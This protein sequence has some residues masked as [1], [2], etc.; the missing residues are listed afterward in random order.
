[1]NFDL[2]L[3]IRAFTIT[4]AVISMLFLY[5]SYRLYLFAPLMPYILYCITFPGPDDEVSDLES[6]RHSKI[7][8][9]EDLTV[10]FTLYIFPFPKF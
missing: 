10:S 2:F 6:A 3:I 5:L 7:I 9:C 4:I 1:M 8:L